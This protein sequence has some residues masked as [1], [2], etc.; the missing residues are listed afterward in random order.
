MA[1]QNDP[2]RPT[3]DP[4]EE[5]R[6]NT[7]KAAGREVDSGKRDRQN[8]DRGHADEGNA[9]Q[10]QSDATNDA[11]ALAGVEQPTAGTESDAN[12]LSPADDADGDRRRKQYEA[13]AT[14]VSKLD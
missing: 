13:G 5:E 12:G 3:A 11:T 10:R 2:T 4:L 8:L 14:L 7:G 9:A 6:R 1:R